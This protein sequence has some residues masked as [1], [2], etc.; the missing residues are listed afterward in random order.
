MA[1]DS[2]PPAAVTGEVAAPPAPG[3]IADTVARLFLWARRA[4]KGLAQVEYDNEF[5]RRAVV[6]DL[7][8]KCEAAGIP[9]HEIDMP[10]YW[11]AA[12]V[13]HFLNAELNL[14]AREIQSGGVVSLHGFATA[15]SPDLPLIES[16]R[17]LNFN[18]DRLARF[19]LCQIWWMTPAVTEIFLRALPDLNSF[20]LVR[21]HLT[22]SIS[23]PDESLLPTRSDLAPRDL[24]NFADAER[25]GAYLT[26]R[27]RRALEAGAP[28]A[29]VSSMAHAAA[30]TL[31][32]AGAESEAQT[33]AARLVRQM[34]QMRLPQ[35]VLPAVEQDTPHAP[36]LWDAALDSDE[37]V[38]PVTFTRPATFICLARL[39]EWWGKVKSAEGLYDEALKC[40]EVDLGEEHPT[41]AV[42]L[43]DLGWLYLAQSRLDEAAAVRERA[44]FIQEAANHPDHPRIAATLNNLAN[45]YCRQGRFSEAEALCRRA[46]LIWEKAFGPGHVNVATVTNSLAVALFAQGR[47]AEAEPLMQRTLLIGQKTLGSDHP[48]V[49]IR[50]K[51]YAHLLRVMGRDAQAEA[52]EA[53]AAI[54]AKHAGP[55]K[56]GVND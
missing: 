38:R 10:V 3:S 21:L 17:V 33:L 35:A 4:P 49:A 29:D 37:K 6:D 24:V 40:A 25:Q 36:R 43:I 45:V 30:E 48:E 22:E 1:Q 8:Q 27:F 23:P 11:P 13:V 5:A 12:D 42:I 39:Y 44:L 47:Y 18:R 56:D 20:F 41:V 15:F 7:R 32:N 26:E 46:L 50:R 2:P 16:L 34:A 28:L 53:R 51:N 55:E 54:R 31:R 52:M 14:L 19:P 9:F